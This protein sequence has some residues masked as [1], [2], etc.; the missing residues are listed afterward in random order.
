MSIEQD[1]LRDMITKAQRIMQSSK[2][3]ASEERYQTSNPE[4]EQT[5][6]STQ[7]APQPQNE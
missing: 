3:T 5:D 7:K 4:Q 2:D 6:G 1:K